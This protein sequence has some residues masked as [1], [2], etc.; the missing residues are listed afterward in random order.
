MTAFHTKIDIQGLDQLI[1]AWSV[2][3]DITREELLRTTTEADLL[4]ERETKEGTPRGV[5]GNLRSSITSREESLADNV[6]GVV[7]TPLNYAIPVELGSKPH[8]PPI[9]P[10]KDWVRHK[11]DV[12]AEEVEDVAYRV[13]WH[14]SHHG[15][16]GAHM[17]Q[18][19]FDNNRAQIERMYDDAQ[20]RIVNRLAGNA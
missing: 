11:L 7:G 14:I 9:E 5:S 4:L 15:T 19:A 3:P 17:F 6:I 18:Q 8:F 13:A 20:R 2:A 10:L 16:E 1:N 12:P